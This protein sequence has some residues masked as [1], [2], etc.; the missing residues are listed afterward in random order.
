MS[1]LSLQVRNDVDEMFKVACAGSV[2]RTLTCPGRG[3]RAAFA[4]PALDEVHA[5]SG[6]AH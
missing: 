1:R 2:L 6:R 3:V 4:A 5:G